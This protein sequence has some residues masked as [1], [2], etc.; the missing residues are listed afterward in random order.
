M[1]ENIIWTPKKVTLGAF[2]LCFFLVG[3][4]FWQ[5]P[6]SR[7]SVPNSFFGIGAL[8]VFV[9][10]TVLCAVFEFSFQ[11]GLIVPGLAFPAT[12]MI[13]VVIEGIMEPG[14][15]NLWP[16]A[17]IIAA[18]TGLVVGGAGALLGC[19]MARLFR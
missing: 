11:K 13:R 1:A 5:I 12:L 15:H 8:G 16:L 3:I 14:R 18:L 19:L 9:A 17:L 10:A 6:Y 2:L 7:V 4:P